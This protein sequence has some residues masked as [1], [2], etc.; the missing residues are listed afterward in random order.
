MIYKILIVLFATLNITVMANNHENDVEK[1]E[2]TNEEKS[3]TTLS[4]KVVLPKI[5]EKY[6]DKDMA[7]YEEELN[8]GGFSI[9]T[10]KNNNTNSKIDI[11]YSLKVID[12]KK[13]TKYLNKK[14]TNMLTEIGRKKLQNIFDS[15]INTSGVVLNVH[16]IY[17]KKSNKLT[18]ETSVVNFSNSFY[19]D[20][21]TANSNIIKKF[22]VKN[23][24]LFHT[25]FYYKKNTYKGYMKNI[26]KK[27]IF[28]ELV[29]KKNA[30]LPAKIVVKDFKYNGKGLGENPISST[31]SF[32]V[33][34]VE[35][36]NNTKSSFILSFNNFLAKSIE[37]K[38]KEYLN[39]VRLKSISLVFKNAKKPKDNV[40][41][42]LKD[43]RLYQ[44]VLNNKEKLSFDSKIKLGLI[45]LK[46]EKFTSK[47]EKFEFN[48]GA[49]AVMAIFEPLFNNQN[50]DKIDDDK[51]YKEL[52]KNGL[53]IA[54][55]SF[56]FKNITLNS[57]KLGGLETSF[58]FKLKP[59]KRGVEKVINNPILLKNKYAIRWFIDGC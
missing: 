40:K 47:L 41:F 17:K 55:P 52:V 21:G 27:F 38:E 24:I 57:K 46:S 48:M 54:M 35:L 45:S 8:S 43:L 11:L 16:I 30:K 3:I 20:I 23:S 51:I 10:L 34:K 26:N 28:D 14:A 31:N 9:D 36:S 1:V 29:Q 56:G 32:K 39:D 5:G 6:F 4:K 33:I 13:F 7:R 59:T 58:Y 44:K 42:S 19:E 25:E 53:V 12:N 37:K 22:L 50:I 49:N 2:H 18:L 15:G